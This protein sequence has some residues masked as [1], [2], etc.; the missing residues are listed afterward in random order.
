MIFIEI[1]LKIS[2]LNDQFCSKITYFFNDCLGPLSFVLSF[3][4]KWP[5]SIKNTT[6]DQFWWKITYFLLQLRKSSSIFGE[7]SIDLSS[8]LI[9]FSQKLTK[10]LFSLEN[11]KLKWSIL[12]KNHLFLQRLIGSNII[13]GWILDWFEIK[14]S[15]NWPFWVKNYLFC[16]TTE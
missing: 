14:F 4:Q 13:F 12:I 5:F 6:N 9:I 8:K 16:S 2:S 3:S 15:Q 1:H 11:F 7:F 10:L